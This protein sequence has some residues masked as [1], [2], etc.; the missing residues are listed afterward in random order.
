MINTNNKN[1]IIICIELNFFFNKQENI[2]RNFLLCI[3]YYLIRMI[4]FDI[5]SDQYWC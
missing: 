4:D 2:K 5:W 1:K 3:A